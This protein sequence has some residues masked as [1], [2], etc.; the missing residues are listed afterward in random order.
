MGRE[1]SGMTLPTDRRDMHPEINSSKKAHPRLRPPS[2]GERLIRKAGSTS[3]L[4]K[5]FQPPC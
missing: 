2:W 5:K 1:N 4:R 3:F